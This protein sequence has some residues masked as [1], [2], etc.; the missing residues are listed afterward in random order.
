M[1]RITISFVL[2]L[3]LYCAPLPRVQTCH[4]LLNSLPRSLINIH[5]YMNHT[6]TYMRHVNPIHIGQRRI[7]LGSQKPLTLTTIHFTIHTHSIHSTRYLSPSSIGPDVDMPLEGV[8]PLLASR[9]A[10]RSERCII[11]GLLPWACA[12]VC[13]HVDIHRKKRGYSCAIFTYAFT[14]IHVYVPPL[15]IQHRQF[16]LLDTLSI[17]TASNGCTV[18]PIYQ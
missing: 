1:G 14:L 3:T 10:V 5:T 13:L 15:R 12:A 2:M 18:R 11:E 9:C 7:V 17:L 6:H 16:V 8:R 4:S